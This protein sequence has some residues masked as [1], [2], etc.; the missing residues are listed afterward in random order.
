MSKK[1]PRAYV[2][3]RHLIEKAM[4][5]LDARK[6]RERRAKWAAGQK[7]RHKRERERKLAK[8]ADLR[9][10]GILCQ[11]GGPADR[12][13]RLP[14]AGWKVMASR[15]SREA[16]MSFSDIRVV[17][18]EYSKNSL[19]AWIQ[20]KL[21]Q[22]GLVERAGNP[23]FDDSI[24]AGLQVECRYIYRLSAEG[25]GRAVEWRQAIGE[26]ERSYE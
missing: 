4:A 11:R 24:A 15:M 13:R 20:Q 21:R 7:L 16:W 9:A 8:Q 19:K 1:G 17:C 25:A 22:K 18:P 3:D 14:I 10:T 26:E 23:A 12:T 2:F 5:R 6:Q